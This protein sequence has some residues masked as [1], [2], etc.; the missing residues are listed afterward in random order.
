VMHFKETRLVIL[1]LLR[2]I[3]TRR[4]TSESGTGKD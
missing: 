4:S 1:R 3:P 2:E